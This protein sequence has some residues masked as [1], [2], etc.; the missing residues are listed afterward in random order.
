MAKV[1]QFEELNVRKISYEVCLEIYK[2]MEICKDYWF[3]D[4]IQR[5]SV[6]IINNIAEWFERYSN[7]EFIRYLYI[8][9]WSAWEVKNMIILWKDLWYLSQEA[10][11]ELYLKTTL[12][13]KQL[14]ALIKSIS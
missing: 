8:A 9:K 6:S 3:K 5:A 14:W 12:I 7:K 1:E 2:I 10:K 13:W 4:Q 11:S